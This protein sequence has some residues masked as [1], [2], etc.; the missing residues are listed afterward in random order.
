MGKYSIKELERLTGI[1]AHT[2]RAWEKR[3][4]PG[5]RQSNLRQQRQTS[6]LGSAAPRYASTSRPPRNKCPTRQLHWVRQT[7]HYK[8]QARHPNP[9]QET[10]QKNP[11]IPWTSNKQLIEPSILYSSPSG[12]RNCVPW[13]L[14]LPARHPLWSP[15]RLEAKQMCSSINT[16]FY[17]Y[18]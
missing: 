5:Y 1:K 2:I 11:P 16:R 8:I 12:V 15:T 3:Y 7:N 6:V 13:Q 18:C 4:R 17:C 10:S 9:E 14:R